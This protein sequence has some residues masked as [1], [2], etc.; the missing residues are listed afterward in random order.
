MAKLSPPS[1]GQKEWPEIEQLKAFRFSAW[2]FLIGNPS[3]S[4]R[5]LYQEKSLGQAG[6]LS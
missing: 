6:F 2:L 4:P 5:R 1:A 3:D